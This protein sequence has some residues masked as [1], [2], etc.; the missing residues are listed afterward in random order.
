VILQA[1]Q[2]LPDGDPNLLNQIID[3]VG[4]P[5][6]SGRDP[7]HH[8]SMDADDLL[9]LNQIA[10]SANRSR[11]GFFFRSL[12]TQSLIRLRSYSCEGGP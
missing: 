9:K 10:H 8:G 2:S 4:V 3:S 5:F 6:I 1:W 12:L 11:P 7:A